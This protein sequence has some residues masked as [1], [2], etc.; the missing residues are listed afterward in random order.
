MAHVTL[1]TAPMLAGSQANWA[2]IS[3]L[4]LQ[5]YKFY[6]CFPK[7]RAW[8]KA[9]VYLLFLLQLAQTAIMSHFAYSIL[10]LRW[11]EPTAFV[12]LPW[13]GSISPISGGLNFLCKA[14]IHSEG[15]Q[16]VGFLCGWGYSSACVDAML[17]WNNK[18]GQ[19]WLI[20]SAGCDIVIT[21]TMTFI[22]NQYR[23]KTPWK[24]TDTL[25]N[26]LIFNT[27]ETGAVTSIVATVGVVLFILGPTTNLDQLQAYM[28][29]PLYAIVL[30]V[31]LNARAGQNPGV[32]VDTPYGG[33]ISWHRPGGM[34]DQETPR[35]VHITTHVTTQASLPSV[36][37]VP[38][39]VGKT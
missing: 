36:A 6:V 20:G 39:K 22:L 33:E 2:L 34:T 24:K 4:T 28:L 29:G 3:A 10:V 23:S 38:F 11:G 21:V 13:S 12:N 31:S 14:N 7:E 15:R 32:L 30:V 26:K 27:V 8:I 35:T 5:V 16:T 25:I 1:L 17:G 19:V 9:L 18:Y 37:P